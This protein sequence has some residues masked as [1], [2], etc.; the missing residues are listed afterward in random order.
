MSERCIID[1]VEDSMKRYNPIF[2]SVLFV[3]IAILLAM[4]KHCFKC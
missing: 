1:L 3:R 4:P 2:A